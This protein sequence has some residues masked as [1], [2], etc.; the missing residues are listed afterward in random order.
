MAASL[1]MPY[2]SQF[3]IHDGLLSR[4]THWKLSTAGITDR[5]WKQAYI[6]IMLTLICKKFLWH[7]PDIY[8]CFW[9][10]FF[11]SQTVII[12]RT[13][14]E[15]DAIS[16]TPLYHFHLLHRPLNINAER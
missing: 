5:N 7:L 10:I 9:H 2:P 8:F 6:Y 13:A 11:L 12:Q 1:D 3:K 16:L 15:G 4:G 14:Q